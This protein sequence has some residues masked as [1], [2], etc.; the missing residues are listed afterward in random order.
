M[1]QDLRKLLL[2]Y[3]NYQQDLQKHNLELEELQNKPVTYTSQ[4]DVAHLQRILSYKTEIENRYYTLQ[5]IS[6][7]LVGF[8]HEIVGLFNKI[9]VPPGKKIEVIDGSSTAYFWYDEDGYV[10][11]ELAV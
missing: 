3:Y 2:R 4:T 10:E 9:G 11:W 8:N 6:N 5:N 1:A 7:Q